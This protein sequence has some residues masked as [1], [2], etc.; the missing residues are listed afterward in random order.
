VTRADRAG[1]AF[2]SPALLAIGFFFALPTFA[3]LLLS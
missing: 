3:A 2:V 1:W